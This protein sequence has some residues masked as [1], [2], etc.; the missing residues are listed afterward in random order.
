[1]THDPLT[2]EIEQGSMLIEAQK[3]GMLFEAQ[4]NGML[5]E[6]PSC[7]WE[8]PSKSMNPNK[9]M[10][11]QCLTLIPLILFDSH[12]YFDQSSAYTNFFFLILI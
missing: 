10:Y 4:K 9:S 12:H 7:T 8:N 11:P 6:A 3:N 5:F 1:M 2:F